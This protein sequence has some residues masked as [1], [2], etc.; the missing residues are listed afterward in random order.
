MGYRLHVCKKYDVQY[1][2]IADFNWQSE[3]VI[4]L[5]DLLKMDSWSS[6]DGEDIEVMRDEFLEQ[7][8]YLRSL[9]ADAPDRDEILDLCAELG[10]PNPAD[11]ASRLK[12]FADAADPTDD[13]LRFT[14]F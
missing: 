13:L 10:Y 11:L 5:F 1:A 9:P 3:E 2:N 7:I 6:Q 14:F 12:E 4:R 8:S